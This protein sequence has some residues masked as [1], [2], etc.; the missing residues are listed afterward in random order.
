MALI[1]GVGDEVTVLFG[2]LLCLLVLGLA[3]ISTHTSE[4]SDLL[5]QDSGTPSPP[6]SREAAVSTVS[7]SQD[8]SGSEAPTLRHQVPHLQSE[9]GSVS[10][11]A[12][13]PSSQT[14]PLVLRLKF[15]MWLEDG[16]RI[17]LPPLKRTQFPGQ[18]HQVQLIYQGQFLDD[19]QTLDSLHL[20]HNCVLHYHMTTRAGLQHLGCPLGS[21]TSPSGLGVGNLLLLLLLLMLTQLWDCQIQYRTFFTQT[22]T[23]GLDSLT[24]LVSLLASPTEASACQGPRSQPPWIP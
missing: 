5:P 3:W 14:G 19:A 8:T 21:E 4:Q 22:A 11:E 9:P 20:P 23:L 13:S 16:P 18:E 2:A 6:Q 12:L 24:L 1:E 7:N 17:P 10:P 15:L